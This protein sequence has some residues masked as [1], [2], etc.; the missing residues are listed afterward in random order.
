MKNRRFEITLNIEKIIL[1]F[2]FVFVVS[3]KGQSK[4][5]E[6]NIAGNDSLIKY[7]E[8]LVFLGRPINYNE[9]MKKIELSEDNSPGSKYRNARISLAKTDYLKARDFL[10]DTLKKNKDNIELHYYLGIVCRELAVRKHYLT[11]MD[12]MLNKSKENFEWVIKHDSGYKDVMFQYGLLLYHTEKAGK[13]MNCIINET[14]KQPG[15]TLLYAALRNIFTKMIKEKKFD[16]NE[17]KISFEIKDYIDDY[18][19][20]N[21]TGYQ[22]YFQGELLRLLKRPDEAEELLN[23][24]L[25]EKIKIPRALIYS[26]LLKIYAKNEEEDKF[27]KCYWEAVKESVNHESDILFYDLKYICSPEEI[28]EYE[29]LNYAGEKFEYYK[30]FWNRHNPITGKK[31]P[32]IFEH[33]KRLVK[34]EENYQFIRERYYYSRNKFEE[35]TDLGLIYIR[36]GEP[37]TRIITSNKDG[38]NSSHDPNLFF[39]EDDIQQNTT[40]IWSNKIESWLYFNSNNK[41]DMEFHFWGNNFKFLTYIVDNNT[42]SSLYLVSDDLLYD[43]ILKVISTS[44]VSTYLE[45]KTEKNLQTIKTALTKEKSAWEKEVITFNMKSNVYAFRGRNGTKMMDLAYMVDKSFIFK[46]LPDTAQKI[47]LECN[48]GIYDKN[49]KEILLKTDTIKISRPEGEKEAEFRFNKFN[50]RLDSC[51]VGLSVH[52]LGTEIYGKT[53]KALKLPEYSSG[54]NISNIELGTESEK[55]SE[56]FRKK[57]KY[58]LPKVI[59]E[60]NLKIPLAAYYEIYNL[61]KNLD[62]KT[63]YK[64]QY[65][66]KYNGTDNIF[67]KLLSSGE[68]QN[69]ISTEY[70]QIG[71]DESATEFINFDLKKLIPG[72][73]ILEIKIT[74]VY[75]GKTAVQTQEV[76]LYE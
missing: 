71:K 74:D 6:K 21:N 68:R 44:N 45:A 42:L 22:S 35:F 14:E 37:D 10:I 50:L 26:S 69:S 58:I 34:A 59:M 52:A 46:K 36:Y 30:S 61:K 20:V 29:K 5:S 11:F 31:N 60:H 13:A 65:S 55:G 7:A 41:T 12:S 39:Y 40:N 27:E 16:N 53:E 25:K 8:E 54:L 17:E 62:G 67:E 64:M 51:I 57:D 76:E 32:R 47:D 33:Y 1:C 70:I 49:K 24:L 9:I 73:Y 43:K 2:L 66:I 56:I 72:K 63:M 4:I 19:E 3:G 18:T 28:L 38:H 75:S 15:N 23:A 48:I